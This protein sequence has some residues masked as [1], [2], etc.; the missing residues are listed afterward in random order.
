MN[1]FLNFLASAVLSLLVICLATHDAQAQTANLSVSTQL[2]CASGHYLATMQIRASDATSFSIGTSSVFLTYDPNSLTFVSYQSLNFDQNSLCGDQALWDMHSS[3]GTSPGLFNLTMSLN[4]TSVSCPLINNTDWVSIGTITF[5][6][7][8]PDGNPAL[9]FVPNFSSFNAVPA[10]N[11]VVRIQTGQFTGVNQAGVLRCAP[12][13]SLSLTTPSLPV[14][15]A[16][17][18]Y[19]QALAV[20]GGTAPLAYTVVGGSLPAGL[21]LSP[22]TGVISGTPTLATT[23]SFTVLVTDSQSC[24]AQSA[25]SITTSAAPVC[26][27]SAVVTPGL[28]STANNQYTLTGT[29]S[30]TNATAGSLLIADGNLSA[31]VSIT[32]NQT[33]ASFS[34]A[35]LTSDGAAHTVS[36]S[37]TGCNNTS[38]TYISPQSCALP[39][40]L[41]TD[42][43]PITVSRL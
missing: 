33:T 13:C 3:D 7:K 24:S 10:N 14:G 40:C 11:G 22:T 27:L 23:T 4:S 35:G 39:P 32:A 25:L 28:C 15:Q 2:D 5:N 20:S 19:N 6:V 42:C 1:N 43:I 29:L 36:T 21:S 30:L 34:L 38:S 12:V 8:N 37:L 9:N 17:S 26:S 41:S 18:A 31:I 16:G